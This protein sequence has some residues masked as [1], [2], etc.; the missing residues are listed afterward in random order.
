MCGFFLSLAQRNIKA[1]L[2]SGRTRLCN[3]PQPH[4]GA[5][6]T[7][8]DLNVWFRGV[9]EIPSAVEALL[10]S[11]DEDLPGPGIGQRPALEF[12]DRAGSQL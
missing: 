5:N 2:S 10:R 7:A 8:V 1:T 9:D 4:R 3:C 11:A 12:R 6:E